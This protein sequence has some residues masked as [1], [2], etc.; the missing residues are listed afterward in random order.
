M[1]SHLEGSRRSKQHPA[2]QGHGLVCLRG[3][4]VQLAR[5]LCCSAQSSGRSNS[6]SRVAVSATGSRPCRIA[7]TR[8]GL[9]KARSTSFCHTLDS[10]FVCG[11]PNRYLAALVFSALEEDSSTRLLYNTINL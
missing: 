11:E 8:S 7:S 6:L 9:R 3:C 1:Q 2:A 10:G 5:S 4:A